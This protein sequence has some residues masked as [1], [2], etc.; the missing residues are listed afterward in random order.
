MPTEMK[1]AELQQGVLI[2][3]DTLSWSSPARDTF[4]LVLAQLY[5]AIIIMWYT[6]KF[7]WLQ[8]VLGSCKQIMNGICLEY[9]LLIAAKMNQ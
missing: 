4:L 2:S 9:F 8:E 7:P 5:H 1:R 6:T 3:Y